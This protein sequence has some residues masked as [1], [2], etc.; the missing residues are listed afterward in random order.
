MVWVN[1][2]CI[3]CDLTH[4]TVLASLTN[5]LSTDPLNLFYKTVSQ[6]QTLFIAADMNI[7]L[8]PHLHVILLLEWELP[9]IYGNYIFVAA[10]HF[11]VIYGTIS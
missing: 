3:Q 11:L 1:V 2:T 10:G 6:P 9:N 5:E 8:P 4:S 7:L